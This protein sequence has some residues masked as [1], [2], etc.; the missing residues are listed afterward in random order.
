MSRE[1]DRHLARFI[2]EMK[3][4][5]RCH[6]V[7]LYGSRARGYATAASDYDLI[8]FRK[9]GAVVRDARKTGGV[10]L[11]AFVYPDAKLKLADLL[12]VR[13]GKVLFQKAGFGDRFL[14][15]LDKLYQRGPKRLPPDDIAVKK[16]WPG[17]MLARI[18]QG[19][20]EGNYRRAMLLYVLLE[21]YFALRGL[22]YEGPKAALARLRRNE[23]KTNALFETAL[24]PDAPLSAIAKLA[25]AV[26]RTKG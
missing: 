17:K 19:D 8:G 18:E 25:T 6:T 26:T 21:D 4:K 22:W 12:R 24:K 1:P 11:D 9:A 3:T 23:P 10:W 14:A 20:A 7:I 13:G 2:R 16:A 15:R 5:H